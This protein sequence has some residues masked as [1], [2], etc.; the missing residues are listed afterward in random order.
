[1]REE[2]RERFTRS[3]DSNEGMTFASATVMR[4]KN[5]GHATR[6]QGDGEGGAPPGAPA[7]RRAARI[8]GLIMPASLTADL[9][10]L[11]AAQ[12][13]YSSPCVVGV[14]ATAGDGDD[15]HPGLDAISYLDGD[16]L[17]DSHIPRSFENQ[18]QENIHM[19]AINFADQSRLYEH[20]PVFLRMPIQPLPV[21]PKFITEHTG[22]KVPAEYDC[23][24][25]FDRRAD[26]Y[27]G[28]DPVW[29]TPSMVSLLGIDYTKSRLTSEPSHYLSRN[30][31][32][33][34]AVPSRWQ[35][36]HNLQSFIM[37]GQ[38]WFIPAYPIVDEEYVELVAVYQ[39]AMKA[40]HTFTLV[41][42]G[43]RWGPWGYRAAAAIRRYNPDVQKVDLLFF[44]SETESCDAIRKVAEVNEFKLPKFNVSVVCEMFGSYSARN[45][46]DKAFR[47]WAATRSVIDVFDMDC[48]GCEYDMIPKIG[49]ILNSKV[50]RVIIGVHESGVAGVTTLLNVLEGW[51]HVHVTPMGKGRWVDSV[52]GYCPDILY[53]RPWKWRAQSE[54][55]GSCSKS[56]HFNLGYKY[57]PM[58]NWDG[59]IILDNPRFGTNPDLYRTTPIDRWRAARANSATST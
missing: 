11:L 59:N 8:N 6:K 38:K 30:Y 14:G 17:P 52:W 42:I 32:Y 23:S 57:G 37:S 9:L 41:E 50:R 24:N 51:V 26:W 56:P 18:P 22:L 10:L 12:T 39:M 21:D 46:D 49:D 31:D 33:Y 4:S 54:L 15:A 7:Q 44:E 29:G 20:D 27:P 2:R 13:F 40:K 35:G 5:L 34:A 43:A 55:E 16:E 53:E 47:S 28:S 48:Q 25:A 36:C 58:I 1:M 45:D 3:S 19:V